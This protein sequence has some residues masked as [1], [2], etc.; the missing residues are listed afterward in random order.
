MLRGML[1][2][3]KNGRRVRNATISTR[4][5]AFPPEMLASWIVLGFNLN[6]VR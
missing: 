2:C 5:P 3:G 6:K 1:H 4:N